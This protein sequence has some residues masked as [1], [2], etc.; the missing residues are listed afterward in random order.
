M[1]P[2]L[3]IILLSQFLDLREIGFCSALLASYGMFEQITD[4]AFF[5]FVMTRPREEFDEAL[6]CVPGLS[7]ARGAVVGGLVALTAP[8]VASIFSLRPKSSSFMFLGIVIFARSFEHFATRVA[9]R[10]FP[11]HTATHSDFGREHAQPSRSCRRSRHIPRSSR[12]ACIVV[13]LDG[14]LRCR[15]PLF[16]RQAL[17]RHISLAVDE[18]GDPVWP[19][20]DRQRRQ[21]WP[22][23][24]RRTVSSSARCSASRFWAF[25]PSSPPRSCFPPPCSPE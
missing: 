11:G 20:L 16:R 24:V 6:A 2:V 8:V 15:Q 10:E 1:T 21:G 7:L 9:E 17:S 19:S 4:M 23:R 3:R 22:L 5:R 12:F 13:R 14:E 18:P 25:T